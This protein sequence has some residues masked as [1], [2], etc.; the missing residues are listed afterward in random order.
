MSNSNETNNDDSNN[1]N[2]KRVV[3]VISLIILAVVGIYFFNFH[4]RVSEKNEVWGAFGDYFGG[5]LNPVIA[6]SHFI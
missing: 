3:L 1:I 4:Y 6:A 5:I 2:T